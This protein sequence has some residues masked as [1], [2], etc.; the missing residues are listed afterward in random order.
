MKELPLFRVRALLPIGRLLPEVAVENLLEINRVGN[1]RDG[2]LDGAKVTL[3]DD[4]GCI[5]LD[6]V[7]ELLGGIRNL[8]VAALEVRLL[9]STYKARGRLHGLDLDSL[10]KDQI[11]HNNRCHLEPP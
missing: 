8:K 1:C 7:A 2:S 11:V 4:L 10:R 5:G 9:A 3:L 6:P